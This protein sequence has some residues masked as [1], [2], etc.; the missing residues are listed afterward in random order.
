[1]TPSRFALS[2]S[3]AKHITR[4][5]PAICFSPKSLRASCRSHYS[6]SAAP[7]ADIGKINLHQLKL[8]KQRLCTSSPNEIGWC[9]ERKQLLLLLLLTKIRRRGTVSEGGR[10][11]IPGGTRGGGGEGRAVAAV[12]PRW[13]LLHIERSA[14]LGHCHIAP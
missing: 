4:R 3:R 13:W 8:F 5:K 2:L 1:M 9:F 10:R 12:L 7:S 11:S 6:C 14:E